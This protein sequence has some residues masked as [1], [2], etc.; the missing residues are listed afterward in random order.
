MCWLT[1]KYGHK[2]EA[3]HEKHPLRNHTKKLPSHQLKSVMNF[4]KYIVC[5]G[6][7]KE[8]IL[9]FHHVLTKDV[10]GIR[11][12]VSISFDHTKHSTI[13]HPFWKLR[14]LVSQFTLSISFLVLL[15]W[16]SFE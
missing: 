9:H 8:R 16:S 4:T 15:N 12:R 13:I 6:V 14:A 1:Q 10:S 3:I 11:Q 7:K 2:Y 5:T